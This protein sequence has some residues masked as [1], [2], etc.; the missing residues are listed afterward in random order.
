M[1]TKSLLDLFLQE[2]VVDSPGIE[3]IRK[4]DHEGL[5]IFYEGS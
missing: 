5:I 1:E 2:E 4:I 3:S